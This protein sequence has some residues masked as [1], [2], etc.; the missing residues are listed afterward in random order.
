MCGGGLFFC[1]FLVFVFPPEHMSSG[2]S[3]EGTYLDSNISESS[4]NLHPVWL[5][6]CFYTAAYG[7]MT[8]VELLLLVR[9]VVLYMGRKLPIVSHKSR[10]MTLVP[11]WERWVRMYLSDK[12]LPR[13]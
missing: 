10:T 13:M 6:L 12:Y 8:E 3:F 2:N 11:L 9:M 4:N 5:F 1:L 7:P